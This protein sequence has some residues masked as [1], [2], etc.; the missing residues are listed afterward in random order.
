L[1]GDVVIVDREWDW[2]KSTM[3]ESLRGLGLKAEVKMG[4]GVQY[5]EF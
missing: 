4:L 2:G 3:E 5:A 1:E